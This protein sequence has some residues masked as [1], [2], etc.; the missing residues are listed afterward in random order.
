MMVPPMTSE[1]IHVSR[2]SPALAV[3]SWCY[4]ASQWRGMTLYP[5][6]IPGG[7]RFPTLTVLPAQSCLW[8]YA[9]LFFQMSFWGNFGNFQDKNSTVIFF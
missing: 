6:L 8:M 7:N 3:T 5:Y 2:R 1:L 9:P 4:M